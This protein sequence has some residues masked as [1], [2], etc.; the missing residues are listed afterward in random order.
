MASLYWGFFAMGSGLA[1]VNFRNKL[2][3]V[4]PITSVIVWLL[5]TSSSNIFLQVLGMCSLAVAIIAAGL[6]NIPLI[7]DT[8]RF[9]DFSYGMYLV[10]FP[11]QQTLLLVLPGESPWL[12]VAIVTVISLVIAWVIWHLIEARALS[13]KR[14][15]SSWLRRHTS[16]PL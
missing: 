13:Q 14:N 6:L 15:L 11:I 1:A 3:F 2:T 7:R 16:S 10:A 4:I 5:A 12:Y 9:G 8:A